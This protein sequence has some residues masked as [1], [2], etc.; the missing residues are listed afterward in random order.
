[1]P[2]LEMI[3]ILCKAEVKF[4][5]EKCFPLQSIS[6]MYTTCLVF[7]RQHPEKNIEGTCIPL[8]TPPHR[9][10]KRPSGGVSPRLESPLAPP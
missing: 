1:M 10:T 3:T 9:C 5:M 6:Y 2:L 8:G 4:A 7:A